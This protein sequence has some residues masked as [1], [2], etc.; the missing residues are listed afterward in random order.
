MNQLI[1]ERASAGIKVTES[2]RVNEQTI[3]GEYQYTYLIFDLQNSMRS[4]L[5]ESRMNL[6]R[7]IEA[8]LKAYQ[9]LKIKSVFKLS[10]PTVLVRNDCK[11]V[12]HAAMNH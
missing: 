12:I 2:T 10:M 7:K 4:T 6:L 3:D 8:K 9:T 11:Y 5:S 1:Y